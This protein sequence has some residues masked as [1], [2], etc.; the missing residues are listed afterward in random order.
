[1]LLNNVLT[2]CNSFESKEF[3]IVEFRERL[4]TVL[5]PDEHKKELEKELRYALNRL[6]EI[7]FCN[8]ERDYYFL[9]MEVANHLR[10]F[11][12]STN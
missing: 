4:E 2:L 11:L 6:E 12:K 7:F 8:L 5:I 3:D 1:M 10:S 9:G